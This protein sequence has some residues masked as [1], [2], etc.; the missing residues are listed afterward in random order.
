MSVST[1]APVSSRF[2]LLC[3]AR[4]GEEK[5]SHIFV[6]KRDRN[7]LIVAPRL[8]FRANARR[9]VQVV[10]RGVQFPQVLLGRLLDEGT[11]HLLG[12]LAVEEITVLQV[13]GLVHADGLDGDGVLRRQIRGGHGLGAVAAATHTRRVDLRRLQLDQGVQRARSGQRFRRFRWGLVTQLRITHARDIAPRYNTV[14]IVRCYREQPNLPNLPNLYRTGGSGKK[15]TETKKREAYNTAGCCAT[16]LPRLIKLREGIYTRP[17]VYSLYLICV[18]FRVV[19]VALLLVVVVDG[20]GCLIT[21]V[22]RLLVQ[23]GHTETQ[24]ATDHVR[25]CYNRRDDIS[26]VQWTWGVCVFVTIQAYIYIWTDCQTHQGRSGR[27]DT[28]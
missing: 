4:E 24:L 27:C 16:F 20:G 9:D 15:K 17:G 8:T 6:T 14:R 3:S 19:G 5:K 12:F 21:H 1:Y 28:T 13:R 26:N 10:Q 22:R 11:V 23:R 7:P 2:F 18:I 25:R